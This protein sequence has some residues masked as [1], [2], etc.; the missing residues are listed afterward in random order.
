M[1]Y[2][3]L[4][5]LFF[6]EILKNLKISNFNEKKLQLTKTN[7]AVIQNHFLLYPVL[8]VKNLSKNYWHRIIFKLLGLV[9]RLI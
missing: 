6:S 9:D 2:L 4:P 7:F 5:D 1:L 3:G 8:L